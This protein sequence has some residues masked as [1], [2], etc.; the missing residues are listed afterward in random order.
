MKRGGNSTANGPNDLAVTEEETSQSTYIFE[1]VKKLNKN[2]NFH[3]SKGKLNKYM[4]FISL[5]D[6][7]IETEPIAF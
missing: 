4:H 6:L 1:M 3:R 5:L 7:Y 2:E